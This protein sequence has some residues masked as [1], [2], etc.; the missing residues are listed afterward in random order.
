MM[1]SPP[2]RILGLLLVLAVFAPLAGRAADAKR[3]NILLFLT[4][5]H[6]WDAMGC[7]GHPF[8]KTPNMDRLA[9]EGVYFENAFVTTSLCSPSR[10][11]I[12]TGQYAHRHGVVDNYHPV[13][14]DLVFF[15]Q[16]LQEAGYDTAFIGK[17]HMGGE[18]DDPQRGFDHWLSFK[19]QGVY[20]TNPADAKVKG[21]YVPQVSRDGYNLNGERI[22]QKGYIT[23]ELT[24][25]ALEWLRGRKG[26]ASGGGED[27]DAPFFLY[28]SHKAVHADFLPPNRH[29][30]AYEEEPFERPVTWVEAPEQF[31]GLPVWVR[32][33]RNSRH[34][35]EFAYY[36]DL[37]LA[38]YYRRYC[39]ALLAVD[40]SVGRLLDELEKS[41]ELDSTLVLYLGD[42]GFLFGEHGLI[43][44]RCAYEES[45]RIPML[46]RWPEA[47]KAGTRVKGMV[48]NIDVAPTLLEVAGVEDPGDVDGQ[49][50]L[51]LMKDEGAVDD[52]REGLL[53]EYYW[54]RNYPQTPTTH[55]IRST[56]GFKYIRYHGVW[57]TDEL[58]DL[59]ADPQER[60]NLIAD[61]AHADRVA[62]MNAALFKAL[63]DSDGMHM[64]LLEDRGTKFLH[65]K[66][67]GGRAVDFPGRFYE[68]P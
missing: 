7:A 59:N 58:Y 20:F 10:A 49:S 22:E 18:H 23:D 51:P 12:L 34:G 27:D 61:P 25:Y 21:R 63:Q 8:L 9:A 17:W 39:E 56:D 15:P 38:T 65:R 32:N 24:D 52:W 16:R 26:D 14:E 19:G 30:Y 36:S 28:V 31:T 6:R 37:D 54:E 68:T 47:L 35:V 50:F 3:P 29:A 67:D 41:G 1:K 33:Q 64:P 2:A 62:K 46:A 55:A 57:D 40:E 42:N 5:D 48:A 43:D 66:G 44:K 13:R 45:M 60:N 4:D 11:S 53:Y